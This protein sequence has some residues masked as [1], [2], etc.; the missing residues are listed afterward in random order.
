MRSRR[1]PG[2]IHVS[3]FLRRPAVPIVVLVFGFLLAS[4]V[5]S[6]PSE[7][8]EKAPTAPDFS[9]KNLKGKTIKLSDLLEEGPV[10]I[11]FWTTW[12]KPCK[13]ELPEL[14]RLHRKYEE[15]GFRVLAISQD[16]PK[17]VRK[18]KPYVEQRK[19]GMVVL[20]DPDR[21]VGNEYSVRTYPTS[22]LVGEDGEIL[23]FAQGYSKGDEKELEEKIRGLLELGPQTEA[24]EDE[25]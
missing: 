17:T 12:C 5:S 9:A 15:H 24:E 3:R 21:E 23:H 20:V 14:D 4:L 8:Q 2:G 11:D 6:P 13:L 22:F 10:L 18:V 25:R 1:V 19:Y 16:D 7:A